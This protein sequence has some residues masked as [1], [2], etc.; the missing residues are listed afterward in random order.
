M[1]GKVIEMFLVFLNYVFVESII[2]DG[3]WFWFKMKNN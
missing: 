2:V 1:N 3:D